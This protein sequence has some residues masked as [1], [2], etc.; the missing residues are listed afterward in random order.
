MLD[1]Y[2]E[3]VREIERRV[4]KMEENDLSHIALPDAPVGIPT[5]FDEQMNLMFDTVALAWQANLTRITSF[6][7]AAE[8]SNMTYNHV[9]VPRRVPC[10][11]ASPEQRREARA[12][13]SACRCITRAFARFVQKL[14][15]T[16]RTATARCSTTRCS[17]TAAT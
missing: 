1:D 9:E 8:V 12:T 13:C 11:V 3:S 15:P 6:M 5:S 16:R 10:A 7:M 4:Q 17:C 2:L 14:K